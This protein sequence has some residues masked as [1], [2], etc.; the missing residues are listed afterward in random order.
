MCYKSFNIIIKSSL[1]KQC[2]VAGRVHEVVGG[3]AGV[4]AGGSDNSLTFGPKD[5]DSSI[6]CCT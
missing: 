1:T 2:Y 3:G 4:G 5:I 6:Y